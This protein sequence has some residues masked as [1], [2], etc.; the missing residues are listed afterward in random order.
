M[1]FF[2]KTLDKT[3]NQLAKI[4][5]IE[6]AAL[7]SIGHKLPCFW[8]FCLK[9]RVMIENLYDMDIS[10]AKK[11]GLSTVFFNETGLKGDFPGADFIIRQMYELTQ[12]F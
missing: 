10:S 8:Y 3:V 11:A 5:K 12:Y 2:I 6:L 1:A 9:L 7:P 4:Q